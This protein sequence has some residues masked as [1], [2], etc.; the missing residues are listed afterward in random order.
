MNDQIVPVDSK[1]FYVW[2]VNGLWSIVVAVVACVMAAVFLP[3]WVP[4]AVG[5]ATVVG[6]VWWVIVAY[7]QVKNLGYAIRDNDLLIQRGIMF[8]S[9]TVVP[10]G[11]MQFVD[12]SS[13]PVS[14]LFGLATVE[15]HTASASSDATIPG[16]PTED[17]NH[18][19]ELLA[20]RGETHL[21]GL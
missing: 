18:L 4:I 20:Q 2:L 5:V 1:L 12:V 3:W 14:R 7:R 9:T 10:F 21:A 19:R 16:L 8:R 13:G 15:L 17:A 6:I 11:R